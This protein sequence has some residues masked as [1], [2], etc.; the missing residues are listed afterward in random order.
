MSILDAQRD[1]VYRT[2][3]QAG[4][5]LLGQCQRLGLANA[6]AQGIRSTAATTTSNLPIIKKKTLREELQEETDSWINDWDKYYPKGR[7]IGS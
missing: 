4:L 7:A 1:D 5:G 2:R 6:F 3:Y